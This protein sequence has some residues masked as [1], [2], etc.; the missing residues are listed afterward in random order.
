MEEGQRFLRFQE[1]ARSV[2]NLKADGS[3]DQHQ[4]WQVLFDFVEGG[5]VVTCD[6]D[7]IRLTSELLLSAALY[8]LLYDKNVLV[9]EP[10]SYY[11]AQAIQMF[12]RWGLIANAGV[13]DDSKF[14]AIF[15]H[16]KRF[17]TSEAANQ[18][19]RHII[20]IF[21]SVDVPEDSRSLG[22]LVWATYTDD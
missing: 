6:F 9:L 18:R 20:H 7:E 15:H 10:T 17:K 1:K 21:R 3:E 8:S 2:L 12:R 11:S 16:G 5:R 19:A 4:N 22:S 14:D 13:V